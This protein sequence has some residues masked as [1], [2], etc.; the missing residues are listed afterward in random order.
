MPTPKRI[1]GLSAD[2]EAISDTVIRS[3]LTGETFPV[4][5]YGNQARFNDGTFQI[6]GRVLVKLGGEGAAQ[7]QP[8]ELNAYDRGWN[9]AI[10]AMKLPAKR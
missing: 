9:D 2:H 1:P 5:S 10:D 7:P 4:R 6:V 8:A 3:K